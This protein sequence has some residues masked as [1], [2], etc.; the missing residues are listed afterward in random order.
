MGWDVSTSRTKPFG[1]VIVRTPKQ[2][3][4]DANICF[5]LFRNQ[6]PVWNLFWFTTF[7]ICLE[8]TWFVFINLV[9]NTYD[10]VRPIR[11][12][13]HENMK[14]ATISEP[15][16]HNTQANETI[17]CIC[18][19][20]TQLA[21]TIKNVWESTGFFGS[22]SSVSL[23]CFVSQT[24]QRRRTTPAVVR[25]VMR[26]VVRRAMRYVVRGARA[27]RGMLCDKHH[28]TSCLSL[29]L[30]WVCF[31]YKKYNL[32]IYETV[33]KSDLGHLKSL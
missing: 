9:T 5:Q 7:P 17:L 12:C 33:A 23:R 2:S 11:R 19:L 32:W 30:R 8:T 4:F 13:A 14:P 22:S 18:T 28:V 3:Y 27:R 25:G 29:L 1:P 31:K 10:P 6:R 20:V 21:T 24:T 15:K 26:Y 16:N